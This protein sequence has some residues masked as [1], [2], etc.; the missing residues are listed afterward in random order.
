MA[1]KKLD[2][3][4]LQDFLLGALAS[5]G[6]A[7]GLPVFWAVG[8]LAKEEGSATVHV[9]LDQLGKMTGYGRTELTAAVKAI[10]TSGH[11]VE[12]HSKEDCTITIDKSKGLKLMEPWMVPEGQ[13]VDSSP[14]VD[15]LNAT[16][17]T[18]FKVTPKVGSLLRARMRD[19]RMTVDD[20]MHVINVKVEQWKGDPKMESFLRPSTLFGPKAV[21][22]AQ[23]RLKQEITEEK[24]VSK[25]DLGRMWAG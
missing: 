16:A 11:R 24:V 17:G 8:Y 2:A 12:W 23:E 13:E 15:H 20:L 25:E 5:S 6:I 9:T 1:A 22:Y 14:I 3:Q 18:S 4:G 7:S 19:D 10:R 21:E